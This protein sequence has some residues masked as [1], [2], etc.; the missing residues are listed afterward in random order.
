M[1]GS[2]PNTVHLV[3]CQ[4]TL[5]VLCEEFGSCESRD[6]DVLGEAAERGGC[7][8][9]DFREVI[10]IG[11]GDLLDDADFAQA[12]ELPGELRG[13]SASRMGGDSRRDAGRR[14]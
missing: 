7:G 4:W 10:S 9:A 14:C 8:A 6:D 3:P 13:D 1:S 11:S 12:F 2:G 5:N